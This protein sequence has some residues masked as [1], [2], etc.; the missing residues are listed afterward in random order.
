[1]GV[2]AGV[3]IGAGAGAGAWRGGGGS[4]L[5]PLAEGLPA[6][7]LMAI[8]AGVCNDDNNNKNFTGKIHILIVDDNEFERFAMQMKCKQFL[9]EDQTKVSMASDEAT[10]W[11]IILDQHIDLILV[12]VHMPDFDVVQFASRV[13][14]DC[15]DIAIVTISADE[16]PQ[17]IAR[18][19]SK[20]AIIDYIVKPLTSKEVQ[21]LHRYVQLH[22]HRLGGARARAQEAH[23]Q[24]HA[25]RSSTKR[26][27]AGDGKLVHILNVAC[28]TQLVVVL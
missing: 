27:M 19:L 10:A 11:S 18:C 17:S 14:A 4:I 22:K 25:R 6:V 3:G 23:R 12:D 13:S 7:D 16:S 8:P 1:M 26:K 21:S 15:C 2:G 20:G 24:V 5:E 28:P 9:K